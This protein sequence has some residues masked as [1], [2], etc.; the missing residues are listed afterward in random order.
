MAISFNVAVTDDDPHGDDS[1]EED[2]S[3]DEDW[4]EVSRSPR[5]FRTGGAQPGLGDPTDPCGDAEEIGI[6]EPDTHVNNCEELKR[7]SED[8]EVISAL[9][10]LDNKA[11]LDDKEY[12]YSISQNDS[13]YIVNDISTNPYFPQFSNNSTLPFPPAVHNAIGVMH[14]HQLDYQ[15][16]LMFSAQDI[17]YFYEIVKKH[18]VPVGTTRNLN[19]YSLIIV[20]HQGTH[21]LKIEN[22]TKFLSLISKYDQDFIDELDFAYQ[23]RHPM[24]PINL[25]EEDFLRFINDKDI[26]VSLY[27][28]DDNLNNWNKLTLHENGS[29]VYTPCN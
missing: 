4:I 22:A 13:D 3:D 16:Y 17:R 1:G 23:N 10:D 28:A 21:A 24:D 7:Q 18:I 5:Y 29:I 27:K 19:S 25:F 26:G 15:G 9:N 14:T 8:P 12:G 11:E 20:T 6:I 2:E